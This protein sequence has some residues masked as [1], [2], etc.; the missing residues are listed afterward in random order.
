MDFTATEWATDLT[1]IG[2]V[3]SL[4]PVIP[5]AT[6]QRPA[7]AVLLAEALLEGGVAVIEVTLRSEAALGA[8]DAI[9]KSCPDMCVGAG[10][11]WTA[12]QAMRAASSGAEF[13]VSPG[14]A[15]AVQDVAASLRLPYL[16]GAQT[17]SEMAHLVRRGARAAKF[18][19]AGPAGGAA[20]L[21]ALA[22]AFPELK[23]CPT[24]GISEATAPDYL[25]LACVPCVGGSWLAT[26]TLLF[27]HD[28]AA[29]TEIASRAAALAKRP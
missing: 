4:S 21:A 20:A 11:V 8:I 7:D 28:W 27:A 25:K 10:T 24:G 19:P 14:I 26:N 13:L 5:V 22:A 29:I 2:T 12:E 6:I 23:F 15:D 3:L 9:R 17:A 1:D 18:F 16:P